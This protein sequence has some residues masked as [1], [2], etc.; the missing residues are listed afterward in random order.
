MCTG[1][2]ELLWGLLRVRG[3]GRR[4][5]GEGG[6]SPVREGCWERAGGAST[7]RRECMVW[8]YGLVV[9]FGCMVWLCGLGVWLGCLA[10][11]FGLVVWFSR[12]CGVAGASGGRGGVA[13][14]GAM[15][16]EGGSVYGLVVWFGWLPRRSHAA[17]R[18]EQ[19]RVKAIHRADA[20]GLCE[21]TRFGALGGQTE[22]PRRTRRTNRNASAHSEHRAHLNVGAPPP[23]CPSFRWPATFQRTLQLWE[24]PSHGP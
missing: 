20:P 4:R 3:G 8:L 24:H 5:G 16:G 19:P 15:E 9:W 18:R 6:G 21:P 12:R 1:R 2:V 11:L 22:T 14:E 17:S 10:W 7:S 23:P 13:S